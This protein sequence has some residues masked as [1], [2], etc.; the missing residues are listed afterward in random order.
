M[1]RSIEVVI[2][3]RSKK[4]IDKILRKN[5]DVRIAFN[6]AVERLRAD[7]LLG[8]AVSK[9]RFPSEIVKE[10]HPTNLFVYDL[11]RSHPGWRML[12]T[13]TSEG[14]VKILVVILA[15]LDH[16]DYD[17]WFGY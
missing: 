15:V 5:S 8:K 7:Y 16:H 6:K 1:M 11:I 10:F 4:K 14:K 12:Y 13:I 2:D 17:R 9:E 3:N